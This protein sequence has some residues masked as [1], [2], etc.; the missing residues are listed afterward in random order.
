M[1]G[2][3]GVPAAVPSPLPVF[4]PG[5]VPGMHSGSMQYVYGDVYGNGAAAPVYFMSAQQSTPYL[6]ATSAGTMPEKKTTKARP[7]TS[8]SSTVP[9]V[10]VSAAATAAAAAQRPKA[11]KTTTAQSVVAAPAI[12]EDE[13]P[14]TLEEIM[15]AYDPTHVNAGA[16][17]F[18][19]RL[20]ATKYGVTNFTG[21]SAILHTYRDPTTSIL[22]TSIHNL[23][24]PFRNVRVEGVPSLPLPAIMHSNWPFLINGHVPAMVTPD[25]IAELLPFRVPNVLWEYSTTMG[26]CMFNHYNFIPVLQYRRLTTELFARTV[27]LS[28][29]DAQLQQRKI[30]YMTGKPS[31][32]QEGIYFISLDLQRCFNGAVAPA[33]KMLTPL[34]ELKSVP[35]TMIEYQTVHE[36][37]IIEYVSG[38]A[39][40]MNRAFI[41]AFIEFLDAARCFY[42]GTKIKDERISIQQSELPIYLKHRNPPLKQTMTDDCP[43]RYWVA[44]SKNTVQWAND[45]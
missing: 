13:K 43:I 38:V 39:V 40:G 25:R 12:S 29:E 30:R 35:M 3:P 2:V 11:A 36:S 28:K 19:Y 10:V 45:P 31:K 15:H 14:P 20:D 1:P 26:A 34:I 7:T 18:K 23:Y 16:Y 33:V 27:Y 9:R 42:T 6:K 22:F 24:R 5:M 32:V 4:T 17:G 44:P 8:T 37:R 41:G 21:K